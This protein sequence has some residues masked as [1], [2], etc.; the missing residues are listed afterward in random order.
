[1]NTHVD[2]KLGLLLSIASID[3]Y[4]N[5]KPFHVIIFGN[6]LY[7]ANAM[8]REIGNLA[9][10]FEMPLN[11]FEAAYWMKE[12]TIEAGPA[13]M[14]RN[15]VCYIGDWARLRPKNSRRILSEIES[16]NVMIEKI[17]APYPLSCVMWAFWSSTKRPK[18]DLDMITTFLG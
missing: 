7:T 11:D 5:K 13:L 16:G 17:A 12:N 2:L 1:M 18:K 14:A 8:M 15:G 3:R 6:D 10:R 9:Q 4:S